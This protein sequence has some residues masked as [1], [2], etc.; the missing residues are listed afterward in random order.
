MSESPRTKQLIFPVCLLGV[1]LTG[2]LAAYAQSTARKLV[3]RVDPVYPFVLQERGI[4]GT[5]RLKLIVQ[6]DGK[7]RAVHVEGGNPILVESATRAAKDW[8]YAPATGETTE[9]AVVNFHLTKSVPT[10]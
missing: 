1:L 5:V 3:T 6:A 9:E 10:P 7:V 8:R 2:Y 4:E